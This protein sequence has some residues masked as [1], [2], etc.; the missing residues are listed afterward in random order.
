MNYFGE[1]IELRRHIQEERGTVKCNRVNNYGK[2]TSTTIPVSYTH[3][4]V[5]K[6][7]MLRK[8]ANSLLFWSSLSTPL[9]MATKWTPCCRKNTLS[10]IHI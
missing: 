3:L 2:K 8:G 10:L 9:A 5:Y 6:R 1:L 4:D 7:Q